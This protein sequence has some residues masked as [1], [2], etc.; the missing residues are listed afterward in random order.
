MFPLPQGHG[1]RSGHH[2]VLRAVAVL[3]EPGAIQKFGQHKLTI[4][5]IWH[6]HI[7]TALNHRRQTPKNK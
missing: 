7:I 3:Y 4:L 1:N 6:G 5:S 2:P